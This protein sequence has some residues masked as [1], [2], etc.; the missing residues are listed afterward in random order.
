[1]FYKKE[2][3]LLKKEIQQLEQNYKNYLN[4]IISICTNC[5][6][7]DF[8]KNMIK[9]SYFDEPKKYVC[10][11]CIQKPEYDRR[12]KNRDRRKDQD[13]RRKNDK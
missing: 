3:D 13:E 8:T 1:M 10:Q 6:K 5:N 9:I 12:K 4:K 11:L 2:I 7:A